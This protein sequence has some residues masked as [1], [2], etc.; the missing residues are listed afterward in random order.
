MVR[1]SDS[2]LR[3]FLTTTGAAMVCGYTRSVGWVEAAAFETVLL[4]VL[5]NSPRQDGAEQRLVPPAGPH[6]RR[7]S[8]SGSRM[9][10]GR[11]GALDLTL[12]LRPY[13]EPG[14]LQSIRFLP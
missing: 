10:A 4:D 5:A 9:R 3:E 11:A 6:S 2:E 1:F 7:V 14:S 13:E 8:G 12:R